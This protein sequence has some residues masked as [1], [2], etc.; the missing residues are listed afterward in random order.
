[1]VFTPEHLT[2]LLHQQFP[3]DT[4]CWSNATDEVRDMSRAARQILELS[5][6]HAVRFDTCRSPSEWNLHGTASI[7]RWYKQMDA[8]QREQFCDQFKHWLNEWAE[9]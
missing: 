5:E 8:T 7:V 6:L 1:M 2:K 4:I 9:A 3:I